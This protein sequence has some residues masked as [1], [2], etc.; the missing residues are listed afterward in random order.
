MPKKSVVLTM[1]QK[2]ETRTSKFLSLVLRHR[3]ETIQLELDENGWTNVQEL[4][5]KIN[6]HAFELTLSELKTVVAN[7]TKQRFSFS[8]DQVRIRANQGHSLNVDLGLQARIPPQVLY[9]GTASKNLE[10]IR[11]SG[12]IKGQRHHVHLSADTETAIKVGQSYGKSVVLKI[13]AGLMHTQG[14]LFYCSANGVW[15]TEHVAPYFIDLE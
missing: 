12:L 15:L 2:K 11:Q 1:D 9:H 6:L 3:P 10:S 5:Q 13:K 14:I 8:D 4:L 7:N